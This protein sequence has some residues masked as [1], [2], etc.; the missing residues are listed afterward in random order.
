MAAGHQPSIVAK[1]DPRSVRFD[2]ALADAVASAAAWRGLTLEE[3]VR[4][5]VAIASRLDAKLAAD[6]K[7]AEDDLDAGR[8]YTQEQV[9]AM[10]KVRRDQR[11][12]A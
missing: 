12:A 11:D 5:V 8:F 3:Y 7:E 9:E 6:L 1:T 4:Q 2:S 10:F